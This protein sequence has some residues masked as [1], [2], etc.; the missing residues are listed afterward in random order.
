[1]SESKEFSVPMG[2]TKER[3]K[4]EM[5]DLSE[6]ATIEVKYMGTD[7]DVHD[8]NV[9]GRKQVLRVGSPTVEHDLWRSNGDRLAFFDH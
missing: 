3:A 6:C 2:E 7:A 4:V 9:L 8:M 1:M 5:Y